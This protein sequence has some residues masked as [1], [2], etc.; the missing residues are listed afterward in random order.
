MTDK[1]KGTDHPRLAGGIFIF[2]GLLIGAVVGVAWNEA[3]LGMVTG[4]AV[5]SAIA[6][7]VWL[8]DRNRGNKE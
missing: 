4:L 3:S 5:G 1:P 8:V 6:L 2:F 7:L